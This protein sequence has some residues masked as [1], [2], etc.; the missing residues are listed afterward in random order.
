M[1]GPDGE[2]SVST[3][4]RRVEPPVPRAPYDDSAISR[5]GTLTEL[6]RHQEKTVRCAARRDVVALLDALTRI[7]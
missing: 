3:D 2:S 1:S 4:Y 7:K 6:I 5:S